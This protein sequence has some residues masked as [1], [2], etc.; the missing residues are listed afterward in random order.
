RTVLALEPAAEAGERV[1]AETEL[2]VLDPGG[3]RPVD[4]VRLAPQVPSE[5]RAARAR[6]CGE[7]GIE[8]RVGRADALMTATVPGRRLGAD[9]LAIRRD[10]EAVWK[11]LAYPLRRRV[12]V[13]LQHDPEVVLFCQFEQHVERVE[14]VAPWFRL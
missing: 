13:D 12:H 10:E 2:G 14:L 11:A 9:C 6:P 4:D 8:R 7:R 1:G 3:V 5:E